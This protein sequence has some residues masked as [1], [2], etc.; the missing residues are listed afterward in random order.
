M[1]RK[2]LGILKRWKSKANKK[3]MIIRGARQVGKTWLMKEFGRL[4]YRNVAYVN[5]ERNR[6]MERLFATDTDVE[7]LLRGL[8]AETKC[9]VDTDT[10]IIFDE[11]QECSAALT[12][13]KY[14]QEDAP[15]YDIIA[16]GSVLGVALHQDTSFPVGKV[17]FLNLYPLNFC[18]FLMAMGESGLYQ[19][20]EEGAFDLLAAFKDK[21]IEYLKYY[22][23]IGGMPE[24]VA[25]YANGRNLSGVREIQNRIL[26][27]YEND[28][29]KHVP[30]TI[31]ARLRLLWSSVPTQLAKENKKFVYGNIRNGARAREYELAMAWLKD[32][33]LIHQIYA[34]SKPA[35]PLRGYETTNAFKLFFL[36]VGLLSAISDLNMQTILKGDEIF[37]EFKGALTE[38]YAMQE[39]KSSGGDSIFYWTN[40]RSMAEVDFVIQT[41]QHIVPIEVKSSINLKA[42]SLAVY[43]DKFA[44]TIAV[45]TSLADF[46]ITDELYDIPLYA[47]GNIR[48]LL[49]KNDVC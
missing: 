7:R 31:L 33:G 24:V 16:A 40:D 43:R 6:N 4:E 36:D 21:L 35:Q 47:I 25:E 26:L 19:L 41:G 9:R 46:K 30:T 14:F 18:E 12:A 28:F 2:A 34:I 22:L 13:L 10:L 23:Y 15:Q 48:S 1:K 44:P 29:S 37:T 5:F 8:A 3:P 49:P 38:Q 20:I 42:K 39:M 11:V 27:S 45:R 17:E 32:C